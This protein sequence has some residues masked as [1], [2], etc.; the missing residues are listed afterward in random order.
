MNLL[1]A[2]ELGMAAGAA[3]MFAVFAVLFW[4]R[5]KKEDKK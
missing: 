3:V 4:P 1:Q 2:F 5:K